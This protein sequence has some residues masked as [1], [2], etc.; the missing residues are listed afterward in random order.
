MNNLTLFIDANRLGQSE[1]SMHGHNIEIFKRK[2]E[3]F[4]WAT[5]AIDGHNI[6]EIAN[7]L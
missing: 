6:S 2:F 4:G 7:A 5:I 1:Q 3:A